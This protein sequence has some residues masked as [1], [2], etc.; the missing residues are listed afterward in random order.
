[1]RV[2]RAQRGSIVRSP[3][4]IAGEG[5]QVSSDVLMRLPECHHRKQ[6]T[7]RSRFN[8]PGRSDLHALVFLHRWRR[9]LAQSDTS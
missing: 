6:D 2:N 7:A 5:E 1:M 3:R 9:R 8:P 4:F